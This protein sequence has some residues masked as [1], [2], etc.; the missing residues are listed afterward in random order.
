MR[1][2]FNEG[3][4]NQYGK[5]KSTAADKASALGLTEA[6]EEVAE[7]FENISSDESEDDDPYKKRNKG[8]PIYIHDAPV[9]TEIFREKTIEDII[10]EQ[11]A[12]LAAQ[13]LRGTPVTEETFTAWR[14]AKLA[15]KQAEAEARLKAEQAKKKGGKGLCKHRTHRLQ[16]SVAHLKSCICPFTFSLIAYFCCCCDFVIRRCAILIFTLILFFY[17]N[18]LGTIMINPSVGSLCLIDPSVICA[19][20]TRQ[21]YV[22]Y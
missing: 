16:S 22:S 17:R 15:R 3:I 11:R 13:G 19:L 7:F 9:A 10:E 5:K 2:L 1:Q 12:K 18:N 4:T 20:L 21:F 6:N 8:G 14:T